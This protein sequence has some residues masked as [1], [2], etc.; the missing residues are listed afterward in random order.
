M[1]FVVPFLKSGGPIDYANSDGVTMLHAAAEGWQH[2]MIEFLLIYGIK[3]DAQDRWGNTA[4][5]R[6]QMAREPNPIIKMTKKSDAEMNQERVQSFRSL[7]QR[8]PNVHIRNK[9]G[10]TPLHCAAWDGDIVA[11]DWL[12]LNY[13]KATIDEFSDKGATALALAILNNHAECAK[14]L[15]L[16]GANI[17]LQLTSGRTLLDRV[18]ES[19]NPAIRELGLGV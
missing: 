3:Q 19:E 13:D 2:R 15:L 16:R 12:L 1:E 17:K 5:H 11:I 7:L 9:R 14:R 6:L 8:Q 4:L 10:G 18:L